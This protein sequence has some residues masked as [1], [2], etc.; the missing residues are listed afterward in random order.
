M[1]NP[2]P[3]IVATSATRAEA[4]VAVAVTPASVVK[5]TA[6]EQ[7]VTVTGVAV[8]DY[9]TVMPAPT[10]NATIVGACRVKETNTVAVQYANPTAGD[11]APDAGTYYFHI[12][13]PYPSAQS[14]FMTGTSEANVGQIPLST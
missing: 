4:I 11:L 14:T 9:V 6:A 10:G 13:R 3:N 12:I 8:G 5:A 7:D 2:G 1:S